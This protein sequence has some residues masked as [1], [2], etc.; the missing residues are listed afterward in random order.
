MKRAIYGKLGALLL[1]LA[2][3]LSLGGCMADDL[4]ALAN[5]VGDTAALMDARNNEIPLCAERC[6][7]RSAGAE[8]G[9]RERVPG[10]PVGRGRTGL[11][12]DL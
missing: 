8:P 10:R 11:W 6:A 1:I 12:A 5:V 4:Q 3:L 7:G 9:G 2:L